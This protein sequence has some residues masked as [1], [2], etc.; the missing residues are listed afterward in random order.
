MTAHTPGPWHPWVHDSNT[1][2]ASADSTNPSH[3]EPV[4]FLNNKLPPEVAAA[5]GR[6]IASAP[7][8][9]A[10]LRALIGEADLGEIDHDEETRQLLDA[11]RAAIAKATGAV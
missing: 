9:L 5:N 3:F 10:A 8:L 4:C 6:L 2:T 1:I 7:D 11:A